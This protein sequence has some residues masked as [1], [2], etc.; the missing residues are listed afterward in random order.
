MQD[1][2]GDREPDALG[3]WLPVSVAVTDF[4]RLC[5]AVPVL[6]ESM[7]E[8]TKKQDCNKGFYPER[9]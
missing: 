8:K 5:V 2:E 6:N 4:E 1:R 3:R 9:C 7:N